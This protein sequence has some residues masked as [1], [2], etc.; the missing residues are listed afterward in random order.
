M[1]E[2]LHDIKVVLNGT[3][4]DRAVEKIAYVTEKHHLGDGAYCRWLW[5]NDK[6]TRQLGINEYGCADAINILYTIG[7]L[8]RANDPMKQKMADALLS[9]RKEDGSFT[10]S[11]SDPTH[12]LPVLT[13]TLDGEWNITGEKVT[14]SSIQDGKTVVALNAN[15]ALGASLVFTAT[16][17]N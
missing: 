9:L 13:L 1:A 8:P 6:Q 4:M 11:V 10:Y 12:K 3:T 7:R 5:Q 15:E 16:P 14:G 17:K 2:S